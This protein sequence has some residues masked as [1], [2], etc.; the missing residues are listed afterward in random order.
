MDKEHLS[1]EE[2]DFDDPVD[3]S[4]LDEC[5]DCRKRLNVFRFL[6]FQVK[7][8]PRM[9]APPFFAQRVARLAQEAK[10]PFSL[11]LGRAARQMVPVFTALIL[12]TGLWLYQLPNGESAAYYSELLFEQSLQ[13]DVSLESVLNALAETPEEGLP[14]E[15]PE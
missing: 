9:E 8:V 1:L 4:H 5:E 12:A 15:E 6:G 3:P 2:L 7:S 13:N 11:L 10:T 14:F